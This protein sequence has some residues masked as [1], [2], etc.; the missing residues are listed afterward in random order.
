M[1]KKTKHQELIKDADQQFRFDT[2]VESLRPKKISV[3]LNKNR[4]TLISMRYQKD[5]SLRLSMHHGFLADAE[6]TSEIIG[7]AIAGGRGSF[8]RVDQLMKEIYYGRSDLSNQQHSPRLEAHFT[9][10]SGE[11]IPVQD[12]RCIGDNYD[13]EACYDRMHRT[14]FSELSK[15]RFAWARNSA[16]RELRSIRFGAYYSDQCKIVLNPRLR[17]AWVA[18]VFVE[19]IFHHELCH[20]R[21]RLNPKR[22]E[23]M[24]S[25]RFKAWEQSFPGYELARYWQQIRLK[26]L[27]A[28]PQE[29]KAGFQESFIE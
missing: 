10:P 8:P 27:M 9:Q 26:Q 23:K 2:I 1:A 14:Y 18:E 16:A 24:H 5:R 25:Q 13:F 19:H 3:R 17:Q 20:H 29:M 21:Q 15:P 11:Q 4:Q 28:A 7:F 6:V 12:I 22:G